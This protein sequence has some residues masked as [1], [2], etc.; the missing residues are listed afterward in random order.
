MRTRTFAI[1]AIVTLVTLVTILVSCGGTTPP[2]IPKVGDKAPDFTLQAIDG[3]SISLSDF[4]GK[5]VM[6]IFQKTMNCPG[7]IAQKPFV[8]AAYE[9]RTNKDMEVITVYRGDNIDKVKKFVPN[10]G[11]DFPALADP[12]DEVG[13]KFGF[14]PGAPITVAIDA[15]GIISAEKVGPFQSQEEI[16]AIFDKL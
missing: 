5:P 16:T 14:S 1:L 2:P 9:Q 13:K 11:W 6:I 10:L 4:K 8:L 7:C 3:K 12:E 15:N